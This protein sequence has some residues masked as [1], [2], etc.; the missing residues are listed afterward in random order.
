MLLAILGFVAK[1]VLSAAT[2]I[3][4]LLVLVVV[5]AAAQWIFWKIVCRISGRPNCHK[6][7]MFGKSKCDTCDRK[8][9][10]CNYDEKNL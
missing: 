5:V 9:Q 2:L 3:A 7:S 10:C 6:Y 8:D 4:G 1:V